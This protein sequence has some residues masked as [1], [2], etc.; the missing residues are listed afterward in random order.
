MHTAVS[1]WDL[2]ATPWGNVHDSSGNISYHYPI[3][4]CPVEARVP[5]FLLLGDLID[6][7]EGSK[8]ISFKKG[9]FV[10]LCGV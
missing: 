6:H 5:F 8:H 9:K 4:E 1:L 7:S 10:Y 2:P 3:G